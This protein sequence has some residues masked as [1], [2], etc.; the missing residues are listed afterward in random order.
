[1]ELKYNT[2]LHKLHIGRGNVYKILFSCT[3]I[4]GRIQDFKLGGG[5]FL[6]QKNIFFPIL[7]GGRAGCPPPWIV[8]GIYRCF[9]MC[10]NIDVLN[11]EKHSY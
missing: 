11:Q 8:P 2:R 6:R 1:M 7:G 3:C 5:T 10:T 4:Q 9:Q